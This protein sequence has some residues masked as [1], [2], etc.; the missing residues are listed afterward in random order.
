VSVHRLTPLST[1]PARGRLIVAENVLAVTSAALQGSSGRCERHEGLA[2]WLGRTEGPTTIVLAA[3]APPKDS[4]RGH[5]HIDEHA[6]GAAA[7]AARVHGLG[8]V[9]HPPFRR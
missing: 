8:V 6:V 3:A 5:V 7:R 9:A 2:L 1:G 4:G